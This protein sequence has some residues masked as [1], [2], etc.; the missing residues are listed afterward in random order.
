MTMKKSH[1]LLTTLTAISAIGMFAIS[2]CSS[3][4]DDSSNPA[5]SGTVD[6]GTTDTG[7]AD[8]GPTTPAP[9]TLGTQI[10]RMGRPAINTALNHGF[11]ADKTAAGAAK[12]AYNQDTG[13]ATWPATYSAQFAANLAILDA[14]DTNC[15]NQLGYAQGKGYGLAPALADDELYVNTAGTTCS[16]YLAVEANALGVL[17]SVTGI[18]CGGRRPND[19]VIDETYSVLA[20]GGLT[21]VTDGVNAPATPATTT[22]PYLV[23]PH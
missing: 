3:S 10:D 22:F 12:D 17:T 13:E 9:P 4:G 7:T 15:G 14:L 1:L 6:T 11:D 18:D 19:D 8:T 20:T 23:A 21:G 2:G 5:D 16:D